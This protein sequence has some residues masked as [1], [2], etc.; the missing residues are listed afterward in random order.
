MFIYSTT[1]LWRRPYVASSSME[2]TS[3]YNGNSPINFYNSMTSDQNCQ[4][5]GIWHF[6]WVPNPHV[7]AEKKNLKIIYWKFFFINSIP[8][9]KFWVTLFF[10]PSIQGIKNKA[11]VPVIMF[12]SDITNTV[13]M[14]CILFPGIHCT[15]HNVMYYVFRY[16]LY[17]L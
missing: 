11:F 6:S 12:P 17:I 5:V 3:K 8:F 13:I 4:A 9:F 14:L 1:T 15:S 10:V 16:T 2:M 7:L